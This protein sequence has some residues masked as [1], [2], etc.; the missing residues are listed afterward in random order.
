MSLL[1]RAKGVYGSV[2]VAV[3]TMP[4]ALRMAAG[5]IESSVGPC[6]ITMVNRATGDV[7]GLIEAE[8]ISYLTEEEGGN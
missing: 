6:T 5:M 4:D 3:P 8:S 1:V 2:A 7:L